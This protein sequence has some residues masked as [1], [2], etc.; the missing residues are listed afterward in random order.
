M[1][2]LRKLQRQQEP[3]SPFVFTSERGSPFTTA[4]F[5]R[6]VERAGAAAGFE[7]KPILICFATPV[8][9]RWPTRGTIRGPCKL[10]LATATFSTRF[11]TPSCHLIG[12]R[13]SGDRGRRC[14]HLLLKLAESLCQRADFKDAHEARSYFDERVLRC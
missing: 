3:K 4:G 2:S 7:F 6:L 14:D 9:L 12:S 10:T 8:G 13:I 11:A 5:A 1:R